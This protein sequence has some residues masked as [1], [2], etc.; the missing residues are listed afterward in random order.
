LRRCG[1]A[2]APGGAIA[3]MVRFAAPQRLAL[4]LIVLVIAAD[5]ISKTWLSGYLSATGQGAIEVLPFLNLVAVWNYGV[6]FGVFNEGPSTGSWIFVGLALVIVA[7]LLVWV[8][9]ADRL[10]PA[11]ALGLV[12]GGALG[13]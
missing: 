13:N 10:L 1:G 12:I 9:R 5:Q 6:S 8:V 3:A 11:A 2:S 4:A 7:M